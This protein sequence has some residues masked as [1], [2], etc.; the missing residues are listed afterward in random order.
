MEEGIMAEQDFLGVDEK[1]L[2]D[3]GDRNTIAPRW[4]GDGKSDGSEWGQVDVCGRTDGQLLK[5]AGEDGFKDEL[6]GVNWPNDFESE[7]VWRREGVH[8]QEKEEWHEET[9]RIPVP[10]QP[11]LAMIELL[12]ALPKTHS[13]GVMA[14]PIKPISEAGVCPFKVGTSSETSGVNSYPS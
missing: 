6:G 7:L 13:W 12:A 8:V 5:L 1:Y 3:K 14:G 2:E 11:L 9:T 10:L 4:D